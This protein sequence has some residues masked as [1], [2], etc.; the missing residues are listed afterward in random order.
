MTEPAAFLHPGLQRVVGPNGTDDPLPTAGSAVATALFVGPS[1]AKSYVSGDLIADS[2][3]AATV[4]ANVTPGSAGI[5]VL[6][7]AR[8][9]D[10]TG[11]IRRARL[12]T[13]D[14]AFAGKNVRVHFYKDRPT[15]SNGDDAAYL[16][17]ESNH[18]GY[19][20]INLDR[21]FTD[22]E[23]GIGV[24]AVGGEI[25]FEPSLGTVNIYAVLE[26][27]GT[28]TGTASKSWVLAVEVLRD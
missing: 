12:K 26:C 18:I 10:K 16:T 20:D 13:T 3:N 14:T 15:V 2:T 23:K 1:G 17:T 21:H 7:V 27:R 11:L 4:N 8:A 19:V 28:V 25:V 9:A 22:Y 5:M 24:P 6:A